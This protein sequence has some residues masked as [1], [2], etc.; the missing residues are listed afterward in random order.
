MWVLNTGRII[1][2]MNRKASV[3]HYL[4]PREMWFYQREVSWCL[5]L[6]LARIII[7]SAFRHLRQLMLDAM[8]MQQ[9][10]YSRYIPPEHIML[11]RMKHHHAAGATSPV[12]T[13]YT[14][15]GLMSGV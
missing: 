2:I 6:D 3:W 10:R 12:L 9:S 5:I 11:G 14:F 15:C 1:S 8:P 7:L 4:R 13:I